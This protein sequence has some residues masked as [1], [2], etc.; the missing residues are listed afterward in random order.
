VALGC[1]GKSRNGDKAAT[2]FSKEASLDGNERVGRGTSKF[3]ILKMRSTDFEIESG[4]TIGCF[5]YSAK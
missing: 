3:G 1:S 2:D 4:G 5:F